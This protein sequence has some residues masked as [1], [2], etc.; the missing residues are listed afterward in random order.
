MNEFLLYVLEGCPY[1][2]G[3][4]QLLESRGLRFKLIVVE[5]HMKATVKAQNG[6]NTF[7]QIYLKN[8]RRKRKIGGYSELQSMFA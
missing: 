3:A 2:R 1:C 4:I 6:M 7:P 5:P 8:G